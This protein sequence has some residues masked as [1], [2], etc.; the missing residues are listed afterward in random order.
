MII[1]LWGDS[2]N[3]IRLDILSCRWQ[4]LPDP[5]LILIDT[6]RTNGIQIRCSE[7]VLNINDTFMADKE[8]YMSAKKNSVL[9]SENTI[10]DGTNS[11]SVIPGGF[12]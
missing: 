4:Y 11:L 6:A 1:I 8:V 10:F 2:C 5:E 7:A 9:H 12:H 3:R